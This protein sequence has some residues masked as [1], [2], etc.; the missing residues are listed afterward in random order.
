MIDDIKK[1]LETL[2]YTVTDGDEYCLNYVAEKVKNHI[3]NV[4]NI[5]DI[6][7]GLKY[8]YIDM[9]CAEFLMF[10]YNSNQLTDDNFNLDEAVS[11]ISLGDAKV[12]FGSSGNKFTALTQHLNRGESELVCYRKMRW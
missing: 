1:R 10:K 2:T 5:P 3:Q 12:S 11:S 9:V 8:V 4:C 6:P 7:D